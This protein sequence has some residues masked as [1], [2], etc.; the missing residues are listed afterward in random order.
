M[1][2]GTIILNQSIKTK[3]NYAK[4][5]LTALLFILKPKISMKAFLMILKTGLTHHKRPLPIGKNK[6][7]IGLFKD[8]LGGKIIVEF[9]GLRAKTW[10]Y[11]MDDDTEHK[12][13]KEQKIV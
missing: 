8:E 7:L 3:Q 4:W 2:Y 11:L 10:T 13:Q 5:V 1:I 6:T 9:V 12:K